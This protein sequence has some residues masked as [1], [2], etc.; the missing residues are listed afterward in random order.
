MTPTRK[1]PRISP[2]NLLDPWVS[3]GVVKRCDSLETRHYDAAQQPSRVYVG[4][5]SFSLPSARKP[6]GDRPLQGGWTGARASDT[7]APSRLRG[8]PMRPRRGLYGYDR[9][10]DDA[11]PGHAWRCQH[12]ETSGSSLENSTSPLAGVYPRRRCESRAYH[13]HIYSLPNPETPGEGR[14]VESRSYA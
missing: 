1:V 5:P 14:E 12:S 9:H 10:R 7:A 13:N 8:E 11:H 2:E 3:P 6:D 4:S